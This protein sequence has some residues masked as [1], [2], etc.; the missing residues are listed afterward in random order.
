MMSTPNPTLG[1]ALLAVIETDLLTTLGQPLI[2]FLSNVGAAGGDP[3]KLAAAWAGFQGAL[4]GTLPSLEITLSQQIS[5][6]LI[7]KVQAAIAKAEAAQT[8]TPSTALR[9]P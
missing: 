2:T 6:A 3:L 5:A 9:N 7:A 4:L 8:P 1:Q